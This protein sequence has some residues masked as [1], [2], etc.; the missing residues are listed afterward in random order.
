MNEINLTSL[1]EKQ[2]ERAEHLKAF[3]GL[4][5]LHVKRQIA[6]VLGQIGRGGI[7]DE[8]TKHDISHIDYMLDSL[9]WIIPLDTH[10]KLTPANWLMLTLAV[11]FHDLGML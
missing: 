9:E 4:K 3:S 8:Y 2:A 6:L 1:A 10:E 11:Y 5:L 7:F